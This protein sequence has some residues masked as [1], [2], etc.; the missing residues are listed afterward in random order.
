MICYSFSSSPILD[1]YFYAFFF[2]HIKLSLFLFS[3]LEPDPYDPYDFGPPGSGSVP[4]IYLHGSVYFH[5]HEKKFRKNFI[6]TFV[7]IYDFLTLKNDVSVPSK[8][9]TGKH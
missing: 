6:S 8:R 7:I 9:N 5:Q 4:V 1:E 2:R 3:V